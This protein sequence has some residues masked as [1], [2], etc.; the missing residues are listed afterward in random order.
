MSDEFKT[1]LQILT[2]AGERTRA[3]LYFFGLLFSAI[4]AVTVDTDLFNWTAYRQ[5]RLTNAFICYTLG[6]TEE[7]KPPELYGKEPC[8]DYYHYIASNYG[9]LLPPPQ[10]YPKSW[11]PMIARYRSMTQ[12]FVDSAY[13]TIPILSMKIEKN[14]AFIFATL[15]DIMALMTL[16]LSLRNEISCVTGIIPLVTNKHDVTAIL[17]SQVFSKPRSRSWR[18][19]WFLFFPAAASMLDL[20]TNLTQITVV[21]GLLNV[22]LW[23]YVVG[24]ISGMS[25]FYLLQAVLTA[26]VCVVSWLCYDTARSLDNVLVTVESMDVP[27]KP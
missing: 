17:N 14:N 27:Q 13:T 22:S 2:G 3:I 10:D 9:I 8:K 20:A 19:W 21:Q 25:L 23:K 5:D 15:V 1:H 18:F 12:A 16:R 6:K 7:E 24:V 4:F 11:E 26:A